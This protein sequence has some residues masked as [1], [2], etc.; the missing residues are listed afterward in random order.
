MHLLKIILGYLNENMLLGD[1][2]SCAIYWQRAS[3][4]VSMCR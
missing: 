3:L 4:Q 1:L 2:D